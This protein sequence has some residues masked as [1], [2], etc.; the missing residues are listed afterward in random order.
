M[1]SR[2]HT[3]LSFVGARPQF[4]KEALINRVVR[5]QRPWRHVLVH[6][7]QHYDS[8]MSGIFFEELGIP[9][10]DHHLGVGSGT[11]GA[12]TAAALA[13]V[14]KVLLEERP[15]CL[16]VYGDTNTTLAGA[17]A[18]VKLGIPVAHIEAG[19]RQEPKSMPEEINRVLTDRI[20][21]WRFCCSDTGIANLQQEGITDGVFSCG[22][23]MYDLFAIMEPRFDAAETA[24]K[25]GVRQN[26]F[27]LVTMHRDFSVDVPGILKKLLEELGELA[28]SSGLRILMPLH[29][30][31][32]KNIEN[33]A[34]TGLTRGFLC[35][36][37]VGYIEL[38]GLAK[39]SALVVT[40]SG[41]L[42][43]EAFY[44]GKRAVVLMPDTCWRE[45]V[46][47]GWNILCDPEKDS[48]PS[49]ATKALEPADIPA[50]PY[51]NGTAAQCI[52][53]RLR[54]DLS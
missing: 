13:G 10:A 2:Q 7:G 46:E 18:A 44:A 30:R 32:R 54:A 50:N 28:L 5:E 22:D 27:I 26:G 17:L 47:S 52:V 21:A 45:L 42:Q 49:A 51:G 29:P 1:S 16:I 33:F 37:P 11:H 34:L 39:A 38:M 48:L 12:M 35:I 36:D 53:D 9:E 31:T 23:V 8:G 43:K 14:E 4:V 40:D 19:L 41:G 15:D 25:Y 24:R 6:S 3:I 20:A